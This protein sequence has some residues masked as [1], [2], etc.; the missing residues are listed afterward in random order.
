MYTAAIIVSVCNMLN[1]D[2]DT[3]KWLLPW[4][5]PFDTDNLTV[6]QWYMLWF[7]QFNFGLAYS[8]STL[9][10]TSYF[11]CGCCYLSGLCDHFAFLLETIKIDLV[12]NRNEENPIKFEARIQLIKEKLCKAVDV[13][14][15]VYEWVNFDILTFDFVIFVNEHRFYTRMF[16]I[17]AA[18]NSGAIFVLLLPN[19]I[20]M[21]LT[22]YTTEHVRSQYFWITFLFFTFDKIEICRWFFQATMDWVL[23]AFHTVCTACG[24]FWPCIYCHFSTKTIDRIASIG[25]VAYGADW[26]DYPPEIKKF[27][28]LVIARSQEEMNFSGFGFVHCTMEVLLKVKAQ[29]HH[30]SASIHYFNSFV[31]FSSVASE[32]ILLLLLNFPNIV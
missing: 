32:G 9:T 5:V 21:A 16:S 10:V 6:F 20:F 25:N 7:T 22:M 18:I 17:M 2:Y 3:S 14:S 29:S 24:L 11:V 15:K 27:L 30:A 31:P 8:T 23:I 12:S 4:G 13:H 28:I 1:G 26:Y 19:V